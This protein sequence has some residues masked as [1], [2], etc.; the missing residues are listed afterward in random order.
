MNYPPRLTLANLPTPIHK[1]ERLSAEVGKEIY[2]WR[3]DMTGSVES[4]NKVRKLE[5]L[6]ADAMAKGATR[7]ITAGGFQ[8][9]HTRATA[10]CARRLGLEVS[11]IVREPKTGF[12]PQEIPTGNL[13]LNQITGAELQFVPFA[14][15]QALGGYGPLLERADEQWRQRG[16]KTYVIGEG[17]S[18]PLGCFGYIY[19]VEQMLSLWPKVAGTKFPDSLF[20]ADGSGGT[21]GGLHLGYELNGLSTNAIWAVN[22]CDSAEYFQ[23]RVG[24][25][26]EDTAQQFNLRSINRELQVLDGHFGTGYGIATDEDLRFYARLAKQEGVLLDPTY[27]GKAFRGMLAEIKRAPDRFGKKIL[28]LHSGGTFGTFALQEQYARAL[29]AA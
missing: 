6:L 7:I 26:I 5:F 9:N 15:Y 21:H 23:K 13:L 1:L 4:G 18:Q 8:S 25:L 20:C 10:Y 29:A 2:V 14:E 24:K 16:E 17:G 27:T 3:D 12:K 11:I 19:G 22:V 28:F